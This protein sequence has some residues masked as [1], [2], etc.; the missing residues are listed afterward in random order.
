MEVGRIPESWMIANS[1]HFK[2]I[3]K[4]ILAK[5][6]QKFVYFI[7]KLYR[8]MHFD[9]IK[10]QKKICSQEYKKYDALWNNI[11]NLFTCKDSELRLLINIRLKNVL[12][13][14]I[15]ELQI[16]FDKNYGRNCN[17]RCFSNDGF[18]F[19]Q[20]LNMLTYFYFYF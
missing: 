20:Y 6:R 12:L 14:Y 9:W 1:R 19:H 5:H 2:K 8:K 7:T 10:K 13:K 4:Y 11:L 16:K 15:T 18:N 17:L 3:Y